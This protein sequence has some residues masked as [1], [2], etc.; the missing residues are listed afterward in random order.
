M[1]YYARGLAYANLGEYQQAIK[2]YNKTI[3]LNPKDGNTYYNRSCAYSLIG[4]SD[5]SIQDLSE[6]IKLDSKY[7]DMAKTDNDF[8]KIR[9]TPSFKRLI[10]E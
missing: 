2:D 10:G 4:N 9:N 8:D 1:A 5:R 6:A 7:S 3:E